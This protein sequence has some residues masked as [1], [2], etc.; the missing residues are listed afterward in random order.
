[1]CIALTIQENIPRFS[2]DVLTDLK[3][4]VLKMFEQKVPLCYRKVLCL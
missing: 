3:V 4:F 1:M 2:F